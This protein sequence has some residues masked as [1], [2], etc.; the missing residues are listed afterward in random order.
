MNNRQILKPL[1]AKSNEFELAARTSLIALEAGT[2]T[3]AHLVNFW[4]LADIVHRIGYTDH[5]LV[6]GDTIKRL[7]EEIYANGCKA[8]QLQYDAMRVSVDVLV[9]YLY[10]KRNADIYKAAKDAIRS[11]NKKVIAN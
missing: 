6:H 10:T 11:L 1:N 5:A 4:C 3:M 8:Q 9:K 7:C 2:A